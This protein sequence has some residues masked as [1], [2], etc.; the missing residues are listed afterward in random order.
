M[1]AREFIKKCKWFKEDDNWGDLDKVDS[2]LIQSMEY[3]RD[4]LDIPLL[5]SPVKG[6]VYADR[7]GHSDLSFHYII[8]R[9]NDLAQAVDTFPAY[10]VIKVFLKAVSWKDWGGVGLYPYVKYPLSNEHTLWGMLHLDIRKYIDKAVW[11]RDKAG[12][13]QYINSL[14]DLNKLMKVLNEVFK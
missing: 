5:I 2:V 10:D 14:D 3:F 7:K 8:P 6:A 12:K 1:T 4:R 13:Y 11:W 9:R